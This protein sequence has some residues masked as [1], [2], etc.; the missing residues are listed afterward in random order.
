MID[1]TKKTLNR[2][3]KIHNKGIADEE[4]KK[5]RELSEI[6][7]NNFLKT[8]ESVSV[9]KEI[10]FGEEKS[11]RVKLEQSLQTLCAFNINR[12]I[13]QFSSNPSHD[14]YN[15]LCTAYF[16]DILTYLQASH[17]LLESSILYTKADIC[18]L[19]IFILTYCPQNVDAVEPLI[20]KG[21]EAIYL[22]EKLNEYKIEKESY[23]RN[24]IFP[25]ALFLS[26]KYNR[27]QNIR[28]CLL[29]FVIAP[30]ESYSFVI[31]NILTTDK[32]TLNECI[33]KLS[34]FHINNSKT[35][36]L[37]YPFH[38]EQWIYFPIEIISLI[39]L[40]NICNLPEIPITHNT[41]I[42]LF[43]PFINSSIKNEEIAS[44]LYERLIRSNN[45]N[46]LDT[47]DRCMKKELYK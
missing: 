20:I 29:H 44:V 10:I 23:G 19:Y 38:K 17:N 40:R 43:N 15:S 9:R 5:M 26:E 1:F 14:S 31:E 41:V 34:A 24:S 27:P 39:R 42:D 2:I 37:T 22:D 21:L 12:S 6:D 7:I 35:S 45:F 36:D 11:V 32:D 13:V 28:N 8:G 30:I 4:I 46:Q 47:N 18:L 33:L 25:L 16:W 3:K